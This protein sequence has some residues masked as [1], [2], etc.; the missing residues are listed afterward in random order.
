MN[1]LAVVKIDKNNLTVLFI[2]QKCKVTSCNHINHN[3]TF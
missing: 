1:V 2:V 3:I